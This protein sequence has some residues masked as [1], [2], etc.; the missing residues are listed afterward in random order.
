[1]RP[2]RVLILFSSAGLGGAE[3][4]L[5]R[6]ALAAG[7][8][9]YVLATLGGEGA[10]SEWARNNGCE[11]LVLGREAKRMR[12]AMD[13]VAIWHAI[14]AIRKQKFSAVYV[15]GIRTMLVLR[16][17]R[18]WLGSTALVQGVRWNPASETLV[19]RVFRFAERHFGWLI[20]C[21]ISNSKAA[22]TTLIERCG[23]KQSKIHVIYN[24]ID[25]PH[26]T[27]SVAERSGMDV[28]TVANLS[29]RKGH[30]GYLPVIEKISKRHPS[31][32]FIFI[33]RDDMGGEVQRAAQAA[34]LTDIVR[35][36]G[37]MENPSDYFRNARVFVLPALERE[38]IPT[39][40]LEASSWGVPAIAYGI[41]GI[42]EAI[43]DSANGFV[44]QPGDYNGFQ[45]A[46]EY[47]LENP[48]AAARM[49]EVGREKVR[50]T[51]SIAAC[52]AKHDEVFNKF[53]D[54]G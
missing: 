41:D 53:I 33:G 30:L 12:G 29:P 11:P 4:S 10:W 24:G 8:A 49:G 16:L 45:A 17:F 52:V 23:V 31:A 15:C 40:I 50:N 6:M 7:S 19:D 54:P 44:I 26:D 18:P 13:L 9:R 20:D 47:F 22:A 39:S 5:T 35:C 46:I 3:K 51:F 28:V 14:G 25:V 42:P 36:T 32:R 37:F 43:D 27:G 2:Q 1:M 38:G 48:G 21:Y 34:G